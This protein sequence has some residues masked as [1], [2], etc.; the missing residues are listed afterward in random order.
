ML[1][2]L[3]S[4]SSLYNMTSTTTVQVLEQNPPLSFNPQNERGRAGDSSNTDYLNLCVQTAKRASYPLLSMLEWAH[5]LSV[6]SV[7]NSVRSLQ[8][9]FFS[10]VYVAYRLGLRKRELS[11][12]FLVGD[13]I[14]FAQFRSWATFITNLFFDSE[15]S[16]KS[17]IQKKSR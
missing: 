8:G 5:Q 10:L 1:P 3:K 2:S 13:K 17:E 12:H 15:Y 6:A 14:Y 7:A 16:G 4:S 11:F 9:F